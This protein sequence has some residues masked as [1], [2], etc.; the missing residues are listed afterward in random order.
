VL[1]ASGAAPPGI[2]AGS[3]PKTLEESPRAPIRTLIKAPSRFFEVYLC[4]GL[5]PGGPD[6]RWSWHAPQAFTK[7]R[8]RLG[9]DR[10]GF[11]FHSLRNTL[12]TT[13]HEAGVPEAAALRWPLTVALRHAAALPNCA[14]AR[15]RPGARLQGQPG[16][17]AQHDRDRDGI[18]CEPWP[19]R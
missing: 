18:A 14:A 5:P 17:Y 2:R 19:P 16:Y 6:G 3:R 10:P 4:P 11:V 9:L 13:L 12:A 8:R 7:L 15:G 1:H